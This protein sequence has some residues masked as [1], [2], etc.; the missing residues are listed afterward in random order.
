MLK[1]IFS[2]I[3]K[4]I[5]NLQSGELDLVTAVDSIKSL[6]LTISQ[7][8]SDDEEYEKIYN[9]ENNIPD[10]KNKNIKKG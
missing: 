6:K 8:W 1:P 9:N 4:V 10:V 3:L 7:Y 2:V 5:T